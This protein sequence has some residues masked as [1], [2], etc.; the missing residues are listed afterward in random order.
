MLIALLSLVYRDNLERVCPEICSLSYETCHETSSH[1]S[2]DMFPYRTSVTSLSDDKFMTLLAK[3]NRRKTT[4]IVRAMVSI[5]IG[6]S[7]SATTMLWRKHIKGILWPDTTSVRSFNCQ[8]Q[9]SEVEIMSWACELKSGW[10]AK[11]MFIDELRFAL[12]INNKRVKI[13]KE[14]ES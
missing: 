1:L 14:D 6:R 10:V 3:R 11:V 8:R 13:W 12:E 5:K 4:S 2:R 7:I 9:R